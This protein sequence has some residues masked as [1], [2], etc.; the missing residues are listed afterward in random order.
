MRR[1]AIVGALALSMTAPALAQAPA[2]QPSAAQRSAPVDIRLLD[3]STLKAQDLRGKVVL[4][5][6][7]ASWSPASLSAL[8]TLEQLQAVHQ[9]DGLAVVALSID[10]NERD[11]RLS[12]RA[13]GHRVPVAMRSDAVFERYGRV[14]STPAYLLI[15]RGGAVRERVAGPLD[16]AKLRAKV[17]ALL[18]EPPPMKLSER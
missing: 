3:G 1:T 12:A 9:Q 8:A 2:A 14:E 15:D 17:A 4:K 13:H 11:A 6:F 5:M 16:P 10:E 7:W 18:A